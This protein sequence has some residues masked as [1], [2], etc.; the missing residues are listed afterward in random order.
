VYFLN[1]RLRIGLGW[2]WEVVGVELG[3]GG[4]AFD[5]Q[6]M[7]VYKHRLSYSGPSLFQAYN[8]KNIQRGE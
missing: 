5:L 4:G 1:V 6:I 3:G 7:W 2:G 8:C